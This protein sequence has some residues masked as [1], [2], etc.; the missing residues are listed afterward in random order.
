KD[1]QKT[2]KKE[3]IEQY[4]S[5]YLQESRFSFLS[6]K[7]VCLPFDD[8]FAPYVYEED[9][10][11][12]VEKRLAQAKPYKNSET[13]SLG[14][15][16]EKA[17]V[18]AYEFQSAIDK[19]SLLL[20]SFQAG[21]TNKALAKSADAVKAFR[22]QG[23]CLEGVQAIF[24]RAG[25]QYSN[26]ISGGSPNWPEKLVGCSNNSACNA[27]VPLEKNGDFV[28]IKLENK[29]Y[30]KP[31]SSKEN[32]DMRSFVRQLSPGS[33][34]ITDNII[35]DNQETRHYRKLVKEYGAGGKIHGHIAVMDNRKYF[36]SDG[37]EPKGPNFSR[38]GQIIRFPLPKDIEIP[39][40]KA[41]EIIAE[42]ERLKQ[43]ERVQ[44]TENSNTLP[45]SLWLQYDRS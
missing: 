19:D 42:S 14:D 40:D 5:S 43:E 2:A 32:E 34:I 17:D 13:I 12:R 24:S 10:N 18:K 11:A 35:P 3:K 15:L 26:I 29:A 4:K 30:K 37:T 21:A 25:Y 27:Y 33:I 38:Y 7:D 9:I 31:Y 6:D 22:P 36:K 8:M 16:L 23:R 41:R 20:L 28:I 45:Y 44:L 39:L 1:N